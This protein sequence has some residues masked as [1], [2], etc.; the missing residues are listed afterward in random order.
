MCA[1]NRA[2]DVRLVLVPKSR[3]VDPTLLMESLF[4]LTELENR[5]P[6]NLNVLSMGTRAEGD[7]AAPRCCG[8]AGRTAARCCSAARATGSATIERRLEVLAG[9]LIAYLNLDEVIRIIR[10]EDEPK[11]ELMKRFELTDIQAEAILNMRLR[12]LRK[13]E[14]MEIRKEFDGLTE[15]EGARS[16]RCSPPRPSSGRRSPGKSATSARR[17]PR[18]PSSAAAA[19]ISPRRRIADL[20]AIQQ[21]MIEKEPITVVV[22]EKGWIRAL[23]GHMADY[24]ALQLQGR[25]RAQARL[26]GP[27]HRQDRHRHHRRQGLHARRRQ[28]AGRA[29]PWRAAAH[30]GRHGQ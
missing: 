7:D 20:A 4:K 11:P 16:R 2:E 5:I 1:T 23:K 13:L 12:S 3:T 10:E 19:P 26:P 15:R 27:D 22:S 17:S 18:R 6:L 21:A 28:A 14:E 30:H 8:M 9:F 29:R 25:R 24:A